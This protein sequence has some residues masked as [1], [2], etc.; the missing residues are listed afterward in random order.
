MKYP[1]N[2]LWSVRQIEFLKDALVGYENK[3]VVYY[4]KKTVKINI[5]SIASYKYIGVLHFPDQ[6][7]TIILEQGEKY[8]L[9]EAEVLNYLRK[10]NIKVEMR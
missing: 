3:T 6:D 5:P 10:K 1:N 8:G 2:D 4:P 7:R 9:K